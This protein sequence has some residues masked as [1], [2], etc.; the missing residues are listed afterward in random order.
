[1]GKN[2]SLHHTEV[3]YT[4]VYVHRLLFLCRA[5]ESCHVEFQ[6]GLFTTKYNLPTVMLAFSV[7]KPNCVSKYFGRK[8]L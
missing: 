6:Y 2:L 8:A 4:M 5:L 1:M 7:G 3:G